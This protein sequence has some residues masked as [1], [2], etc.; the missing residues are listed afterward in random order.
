[1]LQV[2]PFSEAVVL[3]FR[4]YVTSDVRVVCCTLSRHMKQDVSS[5]QGSDGSEVFAAGRQKY[6]ITFYET[7]RRFWLNDDHRRYSNHFVALA[8]V[9]VLYH[10]QAIS[11]RD[12]E[13]SH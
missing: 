7:S 3:D 1:V 11:H 12:W 4:P 5:A 6:T 10:P 8:G 9:R 2:N 13:L